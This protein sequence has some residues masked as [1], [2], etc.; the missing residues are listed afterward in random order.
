MSSKLSIAIYSIISDSLASSNKTVQIF[1][2]QIAVLMSILAN[3]SEKG[4]DPHKWVWVKL[5][6]GLK[7][8]FRALSSKIELQE[9]ESLA[10]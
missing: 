4:D 6:S 2:D 3:K 9:S 10:I 8:N 1:R 7:T 5:Y